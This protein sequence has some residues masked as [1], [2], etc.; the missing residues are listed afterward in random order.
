MP[1]GRPFVTSERL[2]RIDASPTDF[3]EARLWI[4]VAVGTTIADRPR[5]DPYG[6]VYPYGSYE[7][8]RTTPS[9]KVIDLSHTLSAT[10]RPRARPARSSDSK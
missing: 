9:K 10:A 4:V 5:L 3:P 1:A 8:Y 6:R 2:R 7:C